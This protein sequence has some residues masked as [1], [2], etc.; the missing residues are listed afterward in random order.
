[1]TRVVQQVYT[2]IETALAK[3]PACKV[4]LEGQEMFGM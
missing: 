4:N 3:A 2:L 1:M